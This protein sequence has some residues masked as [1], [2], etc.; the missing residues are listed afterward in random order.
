MSFSNIDTKPKVSSL[1]L[2]STLDNSKTFLPETD[3][4][5]NTIVFKNLCTF[6]EL[7]RID[8]SE[9][10]CNTLIDFLDQVRKTSMLIDSIDVSTVA[11]EV[12]T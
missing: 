7:I 1:I 8:H 10:K 6:M 2:H 4:C 11:W 3:T 9:S 5:K 12:K